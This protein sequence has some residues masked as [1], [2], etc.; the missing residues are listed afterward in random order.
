MHG[1]TIEPTAAVKRESAR[2]ELHQLAREQLAK[3]KGNITKAISMMVDGLLEDRRLLKELVAPIVLQVATT[4]VTG[5]MRSKRRTIVN[6]RRQDAI[7][8]AHEITRAWLD[9]PLRGG[10][11]LREAGKDDILA[12]VDIYR[13]QGDDMLHKARWLAAIA[14]RTPQG[15]RAG[16]V[17]SNEQIAK[18]WQETADA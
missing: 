15:K 1:P 5:A 7:D 2:A 14:K 6:P 10:L 13:S 12:Q 8:F 4:M 16:D 9:F 11:K 18:L 17:L 3:A